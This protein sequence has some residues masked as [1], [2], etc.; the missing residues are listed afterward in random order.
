MKLYE[1]FITLSSSAK[2]GHLYDF[3]PGPPGAFNFCA[4]LLH[5][6]LLQR[7]EEEKEAESE[8]QHERTEWYQYNSAGE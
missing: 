1:S 8:N 4:V 2:M 5:K 3:C 7:E 6:V